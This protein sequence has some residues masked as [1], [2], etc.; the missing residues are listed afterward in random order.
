MR[1]L[2]F[3]VKNKEHR[4]QHQN[5]QHIRHIFYDFPVVDQFFRDEFAVNS[6]VDISG[7][8]EGAF[9]PVSL[10]VKNSAR[11]KGVVSCGGG[12]E[13]NPLKVIGQLKTPAVFRENFECKNPYSLRVACGLITTNRWRI[14]VQTAITERWVKPKTICISRPLNNYRVI[15]D[16]SGLQFSKFRRFCECVVSYSNFVF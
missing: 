16:F 13:V 10:S 3:E 4:G 7:R 15:Y 9:Y 12:I 6:R 11:S 1:L 14:K 2:S 8:S 5:K